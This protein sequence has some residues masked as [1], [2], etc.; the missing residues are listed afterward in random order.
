MDKTIIEYIG[1]TPVTGRYSHVNTN[2]HLPIIQQAERK[3]QKYSP[4]HVPVISIQAFNIVP[5]KCLYY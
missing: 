3:N 4:L 1:I 5:A 2:V